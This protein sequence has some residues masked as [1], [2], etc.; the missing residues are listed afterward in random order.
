MRRWSGFCRAR[1]TLAGGA[2]VS[3]LLRA[4]ITSAAEKER[5]DETERAPG[6]LEGADLALYRKL[7]LP[8]SGYARL[9]LS[10][11]GGRGFRFNNPFR[12]RTQLGESAESVSVTAP[13]FDAAIAAAFGDPDGVQNGAALHMSVA[14]QGVS[15]QA[16]SL[17]YLVL[18]RGSSPLLGYGRIGNSL[19]TQPD[20]NV[21][22]ELAAGLGYFVT[23]ALGVTAELVGN[24]FY[25][26]GTLETRY[27]VVPMLSAHAGVIVDWEVLP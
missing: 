16:L 7:S 5:E 26:A 22:G 27:S 21:G 20:V 4:S 25:G 2:L 23:G 17:S 18:Y 9:L 1:R 24:L 12:L 8:R 10:A 15:Q 14:L 11:A 19:L 3:L 13:Y 6:E